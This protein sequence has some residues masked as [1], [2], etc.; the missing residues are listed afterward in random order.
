[1]PQRSLI[2]RPGGEQIIPAPPTVDPPDP[3]PPPPPPPGS[4]RT[5]YGASQ[6]DQSLW[7]LDGLRDVTITLLNGSDVVGTGE[8]I[9]DLRAVGACALLKVTP[10]NNSTN[11]DGTFKLKNPDGSFSPTKWKQ[12]FDN[13][14]NDLTAAG[15]TKLRA[16]VADGTIRALYILDD[17]AGVGGGNSFLHA[18]TY[19]ELEDIC[20]HVKVTRGLGWLP[21]AARG[22]TTYL[23][24]TATLNGVVRQYK[25]L[26]A[27]WC[28]YRFDNQGD[29]QTYVTSNYVAGVA[30]GLGSIAALN[31]LNGG[32]GLDPAWQ[33][34]ADSGTLFGMSP[35]EIRLGVQKFMQYTHATGNKY[36]GLNCWT[37]QPTIDD[38]IAGGYMQL[39]QIRTAFSQ[40]RTNWVDGRVDGLINIRGDLVAA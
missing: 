2:I 22:K 16:A 31:T 38:H 26:D 23:K 17:F 11:T 27:G 12:Q 6:Q 36:A 40:A 14:Y 5:F 9:D 19:T 30:C 20:R 39:A 35:A 34:H 37:S 18:V 10:G 29:L 3:P 24:Q 7:G 8:L 33:L 4:L 15:L 28:Q 1:M 21:T 13:F 25:Y 32:E